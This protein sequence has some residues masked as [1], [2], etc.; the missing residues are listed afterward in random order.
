M[1]QVV[2]QQTVFQKGRPLLCPPPQTI[3]GQVTRQDVNPP[4]KCHPPLTS[5]PPPPT[6]HGDGGSKVPF[7]PNLSFALLVNGLHRLRPWTTMMQ[8][9]SQRMFSSL[10]ALRPKNIRTCEVGTLGVP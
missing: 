2:F 10:K 1:C 4:P 3:A 7:W 6:V 8:H 5:H 9:D